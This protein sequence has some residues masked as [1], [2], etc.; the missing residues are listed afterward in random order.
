MSGSGRCFFDSERFR[1][2]GD[3]AAG[4]LRRHVASLPVRV[5]LV[6]L[7]IPALTSAVAGVRANVVAAVATPTPEE[8]PAEVIRVV[9]VSLI[10]A[11]RATPAIGD[12]V[13]SDQRELPTTVYLPATAAPSPLIV[14]AHGFNGHPRKFSDLAMFWANAGY[15]VAV[16]RFP[17]SNDEF[18][19]LAGGEFV[20]ERVSDLPQQALD[21]SFVIDEMLTLDGDG[22]SELSGRVDEERLG[23]FGLSL[24]SL[25]VWTTVLG[26]D[27]AETRVDALIQS[28]GAFPGG[29]P[30]LAGVPFPVFVAIS[31]VDGLFPPDVVMPQYATLP[32]PKFMLVLHGAMH[33][34]V[35]ENTP[36]PA[37]EAYRVATTVFWD[38]YLGGQPDKPFPTSIVIDGVTTFIDGSA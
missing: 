7:L 11:S 6:A 19:A 23:L 22:S 30:L 1:A 3:V 31:D 29:T 12:S 5:L 17:V 37:D 8:P 36:T 32:S 4:D 21:V 10:D 38:R 15:V 25:T 9:E 28:D 26:P 16:P 35:G 33:A 18:I 2:R 13:G 14:L 34:T 24:G 20:P 27:A